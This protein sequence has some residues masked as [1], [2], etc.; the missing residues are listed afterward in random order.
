MIAVLVASLMLAVPLS[1][2][3]D[4]D[5]EGPVTELGINFKTDGP[6]TNNADII[7]IFGEDGIDRLF[8]SVFDVVSFV[9]HDGITNDLLTEFGIN[10]GLLTKFADNKV[11]KDQYEVLSGKI[12]GEF[13]NNDTYSSSMSYSGE[14]ALELYRYIDGDNELYNGTFTLNLAFEIKEY[15]YQTDDLLKVSDDHYVLLTTVNESYRQADISGTVS[16]VPNGEPEAVKSF[17]IDSTIMFHLVNNVKVVYEESDVSKITDSTVTY[18]GNG[19]E[20]KGYGMD[21]IIEFNGKKGNFIDSTIYLIQAISNV[22]MVYSE[23][24]AE[25]YLVQLD[26]SDY[27]LNKLLSSSEADETTL[28]QKCDAVGTVGETYALASAEKP[29]MPSDDD[30]DDKGSRV[31]LYIG[32]GAG[33][34]VV[35]GLAAF[36]LLRRR[37]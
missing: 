11:Y 10:K 20:V 16:F 12:S 18:E 22:P 4:S 1:A 6:I 21:N 9:D 28:R 32:I 19:V 31:P 17:E 13:T 25:E 14:D 36:F 5:A 7:T 24:T 26:E 3:V 8:D 23:D 2:S 30:D 37:A 35:V 15:T 34:L 27:T 33:A 29:P